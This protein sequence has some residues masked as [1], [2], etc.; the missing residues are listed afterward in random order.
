M[1]GE[2]VVGP[3]QFKSPGILIVP[4]ILS[5]IEVVHEFKNKSRWMLGTRIYTDKRYDVRAPETATRQRFFVEPLPTGFQ[6]GRTY[7]TGRVSLTT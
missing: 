4:Q 5:E 7:A 3:Y 2:H 1:S 6:S